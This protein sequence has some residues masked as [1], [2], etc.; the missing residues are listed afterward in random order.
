MSKYFVNGSDLTSIADAIRTK[1][2]G[3][4]QIEFPSG[5]ASDILSIPT[6]GGSGGMSGTS[7]SSFTWTPSSEI[8]RV[9]T[10]GLQSADAH[11]RG[12]LPQNWLFARVKYKSGTLSPFFCLDYGLTRFSS[13]AVP[14]TFVRTDSSGNVETKTL[15]A[16]EN[17]NEWGMVFSPN[18]VYTVEVISGNFYT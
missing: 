11:I 7:Y 5:F 8:G 16:N 10:G 14:L 4:S 3:T 1:T 18:C 2:G 12:L 15:P 9:A 13:I 17:L 6:G